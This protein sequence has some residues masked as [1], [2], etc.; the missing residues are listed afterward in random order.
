MNPLHTGLSEL[1]GEARPLGVPL[2]DM[3]DHIDFER[4]KPILSV[5]NDNDQEKIGR[6]NYDP[7]LMIKILL[8]QQWYSPSDPQ[9]E[10]EVKNRISFKNSLGYPEK[11]L[12]RD[13]I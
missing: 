6:T 13:S 2:K 12:L 8:L 10:R 4:I 9:V 3:S 7:V 1:Y 11:L 5:L